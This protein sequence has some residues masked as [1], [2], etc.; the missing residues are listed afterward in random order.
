MSLHFYFQSRELAIQIGQIAAD[1]CSMLG[2]RV[3]VRVPGT[4][5]GDVVEGEEDVDILVGSFG[6][7]RGHFDAR[8]YSRDFVKHVVLDEADSLLDDTFSSET[9]PFLASFGLGARGK[10]NPSRVL[11]TQ[12]TL[13]GATRPTNLGPIM[14]SV[15]DGD[16]DTDEGINLVSTD[17][18][19]R[20]LCHVRQTFIR[21]PPRRKEEYLME[22]LEADLAKGRQAVVFA[23][24]GESVEYASRVL[25]R[26][27][28]RAL[29]FH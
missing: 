17:H 23:N 26:A 21:T 7:V 14:E 2:V 8:R 16:N 25:K 4:R 22:A 11:G 15:V 20:V 3:S 18:L 27:G 12:V 5:P 10:R 1:L 19:H 13:V 9:V 28:V 29:T 6:A 24:G